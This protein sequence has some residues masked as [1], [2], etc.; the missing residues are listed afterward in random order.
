MVNSTKNRQEAQVTY[1]YKYNFKE[2]YYSKRLSFVQ[3]KQTHVNRMK[4]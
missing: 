2:Y 3:V 1:R 4:R